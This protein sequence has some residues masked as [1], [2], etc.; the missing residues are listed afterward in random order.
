METYFGSWRSVIV[1]IFKLA[2]MGEELYKYGIKI[3]HNVLQQMRHP[4][5]IP[6]PLQ[7]GR[8]F[9]HFSVHWLHGSCFLCAKQSAVLLSTDIMVMTNLS[10]NRIIDWKQCS[11]TQNRRCRRC[12]RPNQKEVIM[13]TGNK[14]KAL[15]TILGDCGLKIYL[16]KWFRFQMAS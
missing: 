2:A 8:V 9:K 3:R 14:Y 1:D 6:S 10:Q 16:Q 7:K 5:G 12:R 11:F 15:K 13:H 4:T